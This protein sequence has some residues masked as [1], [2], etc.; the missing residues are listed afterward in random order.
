[1]QPG[2][3]DAAFGNG[4]GEK[5]ENVDRGWQASRPISRSLRIRRL[6]E[7]RRGLL[8]RLVRSL[9]RAEHDGGMNQSRE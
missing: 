5:P 6:A 1:M 8:T 2:E 4:C 7:T 3:W 9:F